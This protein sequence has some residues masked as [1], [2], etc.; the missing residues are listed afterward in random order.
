MNLC[1][2]PYLLTNEHVVREGTDGDLAHLPGPTDDYV[3]CPTDVKADPW[4]VDIAIMRLKNRREGSVHDQIPAVWLDQNFAPAEHELLFWLGFPGSTAKRHEPVTEINTRYSWFGYLETPGIPMLTQQFPF[5]TPDLLGFDAEKHVAVHYPS[6]AMR[7]LGNPLQEVPNAKGMSG[8][9][10][11]DTKFVARTTA[12]Q[13]WSADSARVCGV[14]WAAHPEP[15]VV[16]A[17]KIEYV[18][19]VLL[20]F[21][22]EEYAYGSWIDRG[23]PLWE[24]LVDWGRAERAIADLSS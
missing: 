21:L 13:E 7:T 2:E 22:R 6:E 10:L 3:R 19:S 1:Q 15:E 17:T 8:S 18:R 16:V 20:R 12:G 11:W 4:P 5:P 14:I 23:R 24:A 9:L